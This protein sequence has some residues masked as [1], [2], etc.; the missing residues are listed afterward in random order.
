MLCFLLPCAPTREPRPEFRQRRRR[1]DNVLNND[2]G[3]EVLFSLMAKS[4]SSVII[5]SERRRL[6]LSPHSFDDS[7]QRERYARH[8]FGNGGKVLVTTTGYAHATAFSGSLQSDGKIVLVGQT[9]TPP[10]QFQ[11]AEFLIM[12]FNSNGSFDTSFNG[13][14]F[15]AIDAGSLDV[16]LKVVLQ[17]DGKILVAGYMW[18]AGPHATVSFASTATAASTRIL[19]RQ[20]NET[21]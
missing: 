19:A 3:S 1:D 16:A 8:D 15:A 13:N 10:F 11:P 14:G 4:S 18:I 9:I 17:P 21:L 12:R 2:F 7:L 6:R 20:A 5:H